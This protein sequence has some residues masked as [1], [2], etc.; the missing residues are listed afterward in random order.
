MIHYLTTNGVGNAW[1]GN[2]LRILQREGVPFVLHALE[3]PEVTFFESAEIEALNRDTRAIYPLP[4]LAALVSC[5]A[6]PFVFGQRYWSA[7]WNGLTGPRESFWVRL[8][9]LGHLA[10]ACHW[11]FGVRNEPVSHIHS[12]W[13]HSGGSVAMYGAWLLDRPWSF[14]GHAADLFRERMALRDKIER[15]DFI[16]CI[17]EFH[18]QFY[19]DEGARPEQ[20]VIVYCG[21]DVAHF[22]FREK[23]AP[24]HAGQILSS[25]RLVEKKGF[26][27]LIEAC[28]ELT[29]RGVDFRCTIAGSGP[30][31]AVLNEQVTL[32]GLDDIVTITGE[33]LAQER[34]PEFMNG[35]AIYC[36]PCVEAS[37]GDIDGLPQMLMEAMACGLPAVSTDLVGIPDL[38]DEQAGILVPPNDA[39]ALADALEGLL[40]SHE[41][42]ELLARGGRA[43]VESS[44][45]LANALD[46]LV[47]RFRERLGA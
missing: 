11:A 16:V 13:V 36:L 25:G 7:L 47:A 34:I 5:F 28:A 44:F 32:S 41:R 46:P 35:G 17:S 40:A 45:N 21:I 9:T 22:S 23:E 6:A 37:D 18:R 38:I 4:V 15:A 14:T 1:V 20:L 39:K 43:R 12:Q 19:L 8:K 24:E 31:E 30:L 33:P 29:A 26:A 2:E 27:Y 42:R 10:I 3:R